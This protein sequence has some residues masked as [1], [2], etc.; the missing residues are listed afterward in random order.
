MAKSYDT[1]TLTPRF[2]ICEACD[3]L[4]HWPRWIRYEPHDYRPLCWGCFFN[5]CGD[6]TAAAAIGQACAIVR[7]AVAR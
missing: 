2:L 5:R 7:S 1:S 3:E 4:T 6:F